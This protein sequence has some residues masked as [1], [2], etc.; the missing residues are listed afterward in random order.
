MYT[1]A[2]YSRY[3]AYMEFMYFV[4]KAKSLWMYL[5][6]GMFF[7]HGVTANTMQ[8]GM[9]AYQEGEYRQA[10]QI[11]LPVARNGDAKAQY[12]VSELYIKGIEIEQNHPEA[13]LWLEKSAKQGYP[14]AQSKLGDRYAYG[15]AVEKS[16]SLAVEW[17]KRAAEQGVLEAQFNLANMYATGRG[18]EKSPEKAR[19]WYQKVA[20]KGSPLAQQALNR[21]ASQ[22]IGGAVAEQP[23]AQVDSDK[24]W[25]MNQPQS[26]ATIQLYASKSEQGCIDNRSRLMGIRTLEPRLFR[27]T[28]DGEHYCALLSGSFASLDKAREAISDLPEKIRKTKPWPRTFKSLQQRSR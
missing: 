8:D 16:D 19:Y 13:L 17:W 27:Y 20:E 21:L 12:F 5:L 9:A 14:P 3:L 15:Y 1:G 22:G 24:S 6:C 23:E 4:S 18:I 11:W 26:S 28:V 10:L 2:I 25:V 7:V